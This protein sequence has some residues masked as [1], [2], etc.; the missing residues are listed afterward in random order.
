[1][2]V[3]LYLR[4]TRSRRLADNDHRQQELNTIE[5]TLQMNNYSERSIKAAA[6]TTRKQQKTRDTP[7]ITTTLPYIAG[8]TDKISRILHRHNISTSFV[9]ER[10]IRSM[11]RN[12]KDQIPLESQGVY[13]VPCHD[14]DRT[15]IGQT[16]RRINIRKDKHKLAVKGKITTSS[17]FQHVLQTG[18]NINFDN[19]KILASNENFH[20]R[21]IR[22]A[23][24]IEKR[25]NNMNKRDDAQRLPSTWRSVLSLCT[26]NQLAQPKKQN[27]AHDNTGT[28]KEAGEAA[29]VI[30][31]KQLVEQTQVVAATQVKGNIHP[32]K[33]RHRVRTNQ[34]SLKN[35][36]LPEDGK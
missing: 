19:T 28:R 30:R 27:S 29:Q 9:P 5:T 34:S 16:N 10:T 3:S 32:D 6:K 8:T 26:S 13:E 14:C 31:P 22:E 36:T 18:H 33:L 11:L 35:Q 20:S 25:P 7:V 24:E 12:P 15:Y 4:C 1:M 2:D 23:I 21:T 17:L